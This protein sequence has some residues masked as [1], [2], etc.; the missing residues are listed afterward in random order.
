MLHALQTVLLHIYL[1]LDFRPED[2]TTN[3]NHNICW[4][5]AN[6]FVSSVLMT[7]MDKKPLNQVGHLP[8]AVEIWAEMHRLYSG[9]TAMDWTLTIT[10]LVT[11]CYTN[12]EDA[13]THISK[14]KA[15][16][17]DLILM[18]QDI[19]DKLFACFL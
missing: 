9:T 5:K 14:M 4:T 11:T 1:D 13:A 19:H 12:G 7:C 16:H 8:T 17:C 10:S 15:L 6:A 3:K 2:I 18:G